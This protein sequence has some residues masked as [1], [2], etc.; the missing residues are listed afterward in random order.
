MKP[1]SEKSK[2]ELIQELQEFR[3]RADETDT[4]RGQLK[5]L[6]KQRN[7]FK[8]KSHDRSRPE[9]GE[10]TQRDQTAETLSMAQV[11]IDKS[12]VIL[13]RR[14]AGDDP[15]LVYVS[16]NISRF[17]YSADRFLSGQTVFK[18]I[19]HPDDSER[20]IAE[21]K[22]YARKNVEEYTPVLQNHHQEGR[23]PLG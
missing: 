22:E 9:S 3:R 7:E 11:I 5:T 12:P 18:D 1:D 16:E 2:D 17:G 21:I 6:E 10:F 15:R 14:L 13:F 19:V 4:L 23:N 8:L 20:T